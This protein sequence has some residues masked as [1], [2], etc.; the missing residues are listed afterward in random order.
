MTKV[1]D[2]KRVIDEHKSSIDKL[3]V[4]IQA[5]TFTTDALKNKP[6]SEEINKA[7]ELVGLTIS[8]IVTIHSQLEANYNR[9]NRTLD[10]SE[11]H[12]NL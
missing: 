12:I 5:H 11:I 9:L 7:L 3:K 10:S 8:D 6:T 2:V 4:I 1:S